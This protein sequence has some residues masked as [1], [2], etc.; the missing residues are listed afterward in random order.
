MDR[1][2]QVLKT[3]N[4]SEIARKSGTTPGFI[5]MLFRGQRRAKVETLSRIAKVLGVTLDD[6]H[7]HLLSRIV[8][9]G[10]NNYG[11]EQTKPKRTRAKTKAPV[12]SAA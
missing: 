2:T 8:S 1:V 5:S 9:K 10:K 12:S 4:Y 3:L 6:L 11:W 7:S